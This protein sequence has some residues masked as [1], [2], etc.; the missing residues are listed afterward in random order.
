MTQEVGRLLVGVLVGGHGRRMGGQPKGNLS[1][2]PGGSTTVLSRCL[3]QVR[4][5]FGSACPLVLVGDAEAYLRYGLPSVPDEPAG[6]GPIGGLRALLGAAEQQSSRAIAL[7]AD[8]P[9]VESG[10]LRRLATEAPAAAAL[11]PRVAGIWQPL[12]GRYEPA[13]VLPVLDTG[14]RLGER[15]LRAVV[16]RLGAHAREL[17]V[18]A[19]E[20]ESLRDWDTPQDRQRSWCRRSR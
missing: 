11:L 5:A 2:E 14:Y 13:R 1:L 17:P 3:A 19:V 16:R 20:A 18:T 8:L 7:A 15:S 9:H 10:L 6:N 12:F 4:H